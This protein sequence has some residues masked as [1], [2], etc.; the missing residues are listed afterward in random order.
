MPRILVVD[1]DD[2]LR[3]TIAGVLIE[4]GYDVLE[5]ADVAEA[6]D[7]IRQVTGFDVIL[8]DVIMPNVD[9]LTFLS[10]LRQQFTDISVVMLTGH[11]SVNAAVQAMRD[12]A[13]NYLLKPAS[14]EAILESVEEALNIRRER[15]QKQ[16]LMGEVMEGL[17]KLGLVDDPIASE[18]DALGDLT[19]REL[20]VDQQRRIAAFRRHPL[21]L[22]PTEFEILYALMQ[23]RG[24]VVTYEEMVHRIQGIWLERDE[25][26]SMITSHISNLRAKLR[27]A[28][29]GD[30]LINSRGR[31]YFIE[32]DE[33]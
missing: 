16:A 23:A 32:I 5:A 18:A 27:E 4:A 9:G 21:D 25:A 17:Q 29:C 20:V 8:S 13:V 31:G 10:E 7:I 33:V 19:V 14:K 22:T 3:P 1:D 24:Q 11:G 28:N 12:G 26:R 2:L 6:W 15:Q 30:Y